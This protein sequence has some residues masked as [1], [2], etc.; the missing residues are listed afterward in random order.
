MKTS[1]GKVYIIGAGP[2][3]PGLITVKGLELLKV[4]DV[5]VYDHLVNQ[6]LLDYAKNDSQKVDA[7]KQVGKKVLEQKEINKLLVKEAKKNKFVIRLKG[8]DPF[9]FGR[10]GEE[11]ETLT[12]SGIHFEV[13]PGVTSAVAAPAYA[14]IPLTH[15]GLASSVALVTGH[16][17]P[18]KEISTVDFK[19]IAQSVDTLVCLMGVGKIDGIIKQI[20]ESGKS[21]ETP[22]A[23]VERGTYAS[24]RVIQG[25]LKDILPKAR[26]AHLKP[27]AVIVVGEVVRLRETNVWFES[28]PLFG[29]TVVVTRPKEQARLF[30]NLLEQA[31]AQVIPFPTIEV[32]APESFKSMDKKIKRLKEYDYLVFTSVNGVKAFISRMQRLRKDARCLNGIK[33]AAIGEMTAHVLREHFLYPEIVPETFTSMHLANEFKKEVVKG[34]NLLLIRSELANDVLPGQL[35]KMGASVDEVSAYTVRKVN[36]GLKKV[37]QLFRNHGVDLITFTSPSTVTGFVSLMKGE[38]MAKLL[39]GVKV[40]A[41]GPVTK[42]ELTKQGMRVSITAF[43]HT[44]PGLVDAIIAYYQSRR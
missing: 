10:G 5:I 44:V 27:P 35:R 43:K 9:I 38:P 28:L 29:K 18:T 7:G 34:K 13:V 1:I 41:I 6:N 40:A 17:D 16:E 3:N 30:T 11:V 42:K 39:K 23:I 22:V 36:A 21:P 12:Q 37:K 24:Q 2:G 4:A 20:N 8:G 33:I 32:V 19:K 26:K 25:K 14:G 31:G 15:R